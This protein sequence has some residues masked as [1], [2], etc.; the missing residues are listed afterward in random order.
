MKNKLADLNNPSA[1]LR[2]G[3]A[4]R[5]ICGPI[6]RHSQFQMDRA[7]DDLHLFAQSVHPWWFGSDID[8]PDNVK[9]RTCLWLRNLTPLTRTGTLDGSTARAEIHKASPGPDRAERRSKVFPGF[10]AAMALQW[11]GMVD[12]RAT[13][14]R[15]EVTA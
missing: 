7:D 12:E 14:K 11:G 1:E 9:K 15:R 6:S 2:L 5:N 3:T 13:W 4:V 8:G 10:A